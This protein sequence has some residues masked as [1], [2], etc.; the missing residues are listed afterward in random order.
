MA[1]GA[2]VIETDTFG[3]TSIV[4]AEYD[5]ADQAYYLNKTAAELAKKLTAKFATPEKPR[6]VAGSIGPGTK[7]PILGDI[8]FDPLKNAYV[9][10][11]EALFDGGVDL[12]LVETCQDVLQI[13]A[14]LNAI[15]EVFAKKGDRRPLMLS[16][17]A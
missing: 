3:G 12:F 16:V 15:E 7:L 5:L 17:T 14:A 11:A 13:K 10:E 1:A 6:F 2:D 4:L 8:D 9:E